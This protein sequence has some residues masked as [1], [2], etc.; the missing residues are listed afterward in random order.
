MLDDTFVWV[1]RIPADFPLLF[2][3]KWSEWSEAMLPAAIAVEDRQSTSEA[4]HFFTTDAAVVM[5]LVVGVLAMVSAL[6]VP[7][8]VACAVVALVLRRLS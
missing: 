2:P 5:V 6:V 1:A 8:M 3:G 7:L 4:I